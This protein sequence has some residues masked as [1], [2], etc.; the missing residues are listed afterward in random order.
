MSKGLINCV[1]NEMQGLKNYTK[2]LDRHEAYSI[3]FVLFTTRLY[4]DQSY[5][6][7]NQHTLPRI[8]TT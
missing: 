7:T 8:I 5:R 4:E 2:R 6:V 3:L 1:G